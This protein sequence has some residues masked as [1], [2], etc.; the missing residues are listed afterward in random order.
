MAGGYVRL[1]SL[2]IAIVFGALLVPCHADQAKPKVKKQAKAEAVAQPVAAPAPAPPLAPGQMPASPPEVT[3]NAGQLTITAPNSTLGDILRA[4]RTQTGAAVDVP[5]NATER[6]VGK[7]GP[8]PARDV[9]AS[10]L[11]GSHFNYLLLGSANNPYALDRVILTPRGA[12]A[13]AT[14]A[15]AAPTPG[16]LPTA[17]P[18]EG[19]EAAEDS[20]ESQPATDIFAAADDQ[21]NQ[22]QPAAEEQQ[23]Q[24]NGFGQSN[25]FG[26]PAQG[27]VKS[28]DQMLQ[29]LQQRQQQIQQQQQ[30]QGVTGFPGPQGFPNPN[31]P[32]PTPH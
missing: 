15:N 18:Q 8:G 6:V 22:P 5:A 30:Q 2:L 20:P 16:R 3:F 24:Q 1:E 23:Q 17:T 13:T 10:L 4:V 26:Q 12:E 31:N 11:N 19:F 7:F 25:P 21:N 27:N 14:Q 32:Q 28:P 9:L 29:E